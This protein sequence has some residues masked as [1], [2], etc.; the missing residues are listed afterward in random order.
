MDDN[1]Y[2]NNM[3]NSSEGADLGRENVSK[4]REE[5]KGK[6]LILWFLVVLIFGVG[7][8][9]YTGGLSPSDIIEDVIPSQKISY[10]FK[11]VVIG[12]N[13]DNLVLV[14]DYILNNAD[15]QLL[16]GE[17]IVTAFFDEN[18]TFLRKTEKIVSN[19]ELIKPEFNFISDDL[20]NSSELELEVVDLNQF[21]SD[22]DKN[23]AVLLVNTSDD[24]YN[25]ESF[26]IINIEYNI[27]G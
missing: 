8:W 10:Q 1:L 9:F 17:S 24:I 3:N 22:L 12:V 2:G 26:R 7:Y 25:I 23:N 18:T 11:G 6:S 5:H 21:L 19:G 20:Y 13:E 4:M 16:T 15:N 14:G 27:S